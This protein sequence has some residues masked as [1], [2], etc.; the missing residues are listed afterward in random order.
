PSLAHGDRFWDTFT[1]P[2]DSIESIAALLPQFGTDPPPD[3][4]SRTTVN[5]A[6]LKAVQHLDGSPQKIKQ[7]I[8]R[9][10]LEIQAESPGEPDNTVEAHLTLFMEKERLRVEAKRLSASRFTS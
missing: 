5:P 1:W 7:E 4:A 3:P 6:E 2:T 9:D 8:W 10:R